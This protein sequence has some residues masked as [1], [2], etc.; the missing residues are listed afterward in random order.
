[1]VPQPQDS[2]ALGDGLPPLKIPEA[3]VVSSSDQG[4]PVRTPFAVP[5]ERTNCSR[6]Q[7]QLGG[8]AV[9]AGPKMAADTLLAGIGAS[10][11][12]SILWPR[13]LASA[14]VRRK[15]VLPPNF[16]PRRSARL[17]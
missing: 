5:L 7:P 16:T 13:P 14:P 15:K 4:S 17:T 3:Q 11:P 1:M 12:P 10:P 2:L 9:E 6:R 8:S